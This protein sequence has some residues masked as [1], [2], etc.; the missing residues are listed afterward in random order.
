[1]TKKPRNYLISW[2]VKIGFINELINIFILLCIQ[3]KTA[4]IV[5]KDF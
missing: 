5:I 4:N 1:M 2:I 3:V